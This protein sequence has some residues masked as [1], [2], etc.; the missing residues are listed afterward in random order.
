VPVQDRARG[1]QAVAPM[2]SGQPPDEGSEHGSVRPVQARSRV[3]AAEHGNLVPQDEELDVFGGGRAAHQQDQSEHLLE[4]Q[5]QQMQRHGDDHAWP[6]GCRSPLVRGMDDILEPHKGL[7]GR[8][9]GHQGA[10][11]DTEHSAAASP[12]RSGNRPAAVTGLPGLEQRRQPCRQRNAWAEFV[13]SS[14]TM[15]KIRQVICSAKVTH[16][17]RP[18]PTSARARDPICFYRL[19]SGGAIRCRLREQAKLSE[20]L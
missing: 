4:D 3:G 13:R 11:S 9:D 1:D 19:G 2:G 20:E 8:H 10:G 6:G 15:S 12:G 18:S 14:I 16:G 7:P 17:A 5:V